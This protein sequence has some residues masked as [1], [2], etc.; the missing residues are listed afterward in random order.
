MGFVNRVRE[1]NNSEIWFLR[2]GCGDAMFSQCRGWRKCSCFELCGV[3]CF[4]RIAKGLFKVKQT[5]ARFD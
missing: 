1:R 4:V 2:K 5:F 3:R